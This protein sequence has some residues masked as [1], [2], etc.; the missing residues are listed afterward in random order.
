MRVAFLQICQ[1][2]LIFVRFE[3]ALAKLT[4]LPSMAVDG[5]F[6]MVRVSKIEKSGN[7]KSGNRE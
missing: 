4:K 7:K 5:L 3:R 2:F 1:F 6:N